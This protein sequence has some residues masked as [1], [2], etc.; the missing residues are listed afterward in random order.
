MIL[1]IEEASPVV[2]NDVKL[3]KKN[4]FACGSHNDTRT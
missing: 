2:F 4:E 1:T 3:K